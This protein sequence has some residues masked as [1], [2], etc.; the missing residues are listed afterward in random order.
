MNFSD[1]PVGA[2]FRFYRR[3]AVRTKVTSTTYDVDGAKTSGDTL[4]YPED[5]SQAPPVDPAGQPKTSEDL[6]RE[7]LIRMGV[8]QAWKLTT[9]QLAEL[10]A[11]IEKQAP[12]ATPRA[13]KKP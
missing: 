1:L 3:G 8:Q 9:A 11:L 2:K 10:I 4:V 5:D 13:R 12:A 7:L 6:A